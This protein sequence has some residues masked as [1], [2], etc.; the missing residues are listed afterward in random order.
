MT[1]VL[2]Q[3]ELS[4]MQ[5]GMLYHALGESHDGVDIEQVLLTLR[6]PVEEEPMRLAWQ[7]VAERHAILRSRFRW[8]GVAEPLQEV[9]ERVRIPLDRMDWRAVDAPERSERV[10]ALLAHDRARG[11]DLREAPLMRLTLVR[12]TGS[13]AL[14]LWSFHHALLDGRSYPLVL[15]EVF[16]EYEAECRGIAAEFPSPRPYR[17]YIEWLRT[18]DHNS[19]RDYWQSTLAGF[20]SPTPLGPAGARS[21][22]SE[23]GRAWGAHEIRLPAA[24]TLVLR[25]LARDGSVTLNTVL[26]GAWALLLHRYSGESDI[27]F[28]ATRAC[29]R[30]A[31]PGA[32]DMVGLFINT[33]PLRVRVD[34]ED[35]LIPWLQGLRT[36]QVTLRQFE[37]TPLA[38]IQGW[39]EVQRGTPIFESLLVFENQTFDTLLRASGGTWSE[40]RVGYIGQTNF[41]LTL[42][43][44][45]DQEMLLR[46]EYSRRRFGDRDIARM[47]GHLRT[48]LGA[49]AAQPHAR[50]A[51][52]PLLSEEERH[53][54]I[55]GWN[56][57][58]SYPQGACLHERFEQQA[59]RTPEA[60]A[61]VYEG[62]ALSYG[63]LNRRANRLAHRLRELGVQR[64]QLLGLRTERGPEMVVG[65]LGILKAGGAYLPL[66]PAYPRERVAFMLEDSGVSLVL[67]QGPLAADLEGL[68]V[69]CVLL[70]QAL[71]QPETNPAPVSRASDLAYVIYT[72]GST[73][74]PKGALITHYNVTRLFEA[75]QP[76]YGFGERDVWTLFHSYAFDFSVWELWGALLHGARVVIVP[77]WVSRSPEA[78]RE[79]LLRERVTVLNQTPS[80]FRQLLQAELAQPKADSLALRYVVFGGEALELQSLRPWFERYGDERPLLVNM[81][82]ITETTVHVTYRPIRLKD[83]EAGQGSVIGVPIPDLQL[84]ILEPGGEPAPIGVPGEMYVGGAGVARGYLKRAELSAQRFLPDR[85][86][87][88]PGARLYRTGDLARRLENGDIEYLGRID[89]QVKIRGFRIELGEIEAGIARHPAI[90]QV[91]VIAREDSPGDKRLVAYYVAEN[92]PAELLEQLRALIRAAMPEYMLPA[93]FVPLPAL[94][95]THNGK[96]DRKAL[97]APDTSS[98]DA[99]RPYTAPRTPMETAIARIWSSV[100]GVVRVGIHDHFF[101]LGGDSILSIQVIA[102]CR[103]EGLRLTPKDLFQRPTIAKLAEGFAQPRIETTGAL[104]PVAGEVPITPIQRW[105]LELDLV[106]PH[107][108]NQAF[109]FELPAETNVALLQH[110]LNHVVRQHDALRLRLRRNGTQ[111]HQ[112]YGPNQELQ[113]IEQIDLAACPKDRRAAAIAKRAG[114]AQASL[115]L[116]NGPLLRAVHFCL[117]PSEPA[118]LLLVIHHL[119]V[120]GVSWRLILEDLEAAYFS[121]QTDNPP[122]LPPRTTSF[123]SW[124]AHL[125]MFA[126]SPSASR[127]LAYWVAEAEKSVSTLPGGPNRSENLEGE[128]GVVSACLTVDATRALLQQ[129]PA[130]YRTRINDVLLTAL[131]RALQRW[132]GGEAFRIDLEG[133]GRE[134]LFDDVDISRTVGWFT[135]LFPVRLEMPQGLDD[136]AALKAIKEQ[137]HRIPDRGISYGL[138][139]YASDEVPTIAALSQAPRAEV[140]F[141]YLGQFDQVVAGSRLFGFASEPAGLWHSPRARRTHAL[142]VICQVRDGA[143][144]TQWIHHPASHS[145]ETIERV[146]RDFVAA[147]RGIIAHCLSAAAGGRTASDFP[148]AAIDQP[149]IDRFWA[150][151]PGFEDLYPLSPMQHLFYVM[152]G[153]RSDLGFEQWHLRAEGPLDSTLLR[154]AIERVVAR[155][156]ILRSVFVSE[157]GAAPVQLVLPQALLPW[158]EEDWRALAAGEQHTRLAQLLQSDRRAGFDLAQAPLMRVALRRTGNDVWHLVWSTHHLCIDGWSWP[159][160]LREVSAIYEGLLQGGEPTLQPAGTYRSYVSWLQEH[161]PH[162]EPFWR[163]ALAGLA[164]PT[165]LNL[166]A[167]PRAQGSSPVVLAEECTQLEQDTTA[168]LQALARAQ[169]LTLSTILQAAWSL[170]LSHYSGSPDVVFGAALSGRPAELSGIESLV[171]SCVNNLPVRVAVPPA[172]LLLPWLSGL[173]KQ[174]FELAQHQYAPLEQVQRWAKVPWRYRLFDSLIVFQNYQVDEAARRLG[175]DA[176]LVTMAAPEATNYPLTISATP[177]DQLRL[178]LIYQS[179]RLAQETVRSHAADLKTMLQSI[180]FSPQASLAQ[181]MAALPRATRGKA[182]A[183][184]V[185]PAAASSALRFSYAAPASETEQ[186]LAALWQDLFGVD[187]ISLDDN[188]YDLGGHS[189]LLLQAHSRLRASLQPDLPVV[190]LLQYPTI[191]SLARYLSGGAES[192]LVPAEARDRARKQR[193]AMLKQRTLKGHA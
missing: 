14:L 95:L 74:K 186:A 33:L 69:T 112:E 9:L 131:A 26:Q 90:R 149:Q 178:R 94:P 168:A 7:R 49:M 20:R 105:F 65:I 128:A 115:S 96:V 179:D 141:N 108:W 125:A 38:R 184:A 45:G 28:G 16:A 43:A 185:M 56:R 143:L 81:Y 127:S 176:R 187:R 182:A 191:R 135:S 99:A 24:T 192:A 180:A 79:L 30:S 40:R 46:L 53:Q 161:A 63:E 50:L 85:F 118:R 21:S 55:A 102:R 13:E 34:L 51:E 68:G 91:A 147:L 139:R 31:L 101:E 142:E 126:R 2:E 36:Q 193:E 150:R 25:N 172:Q 130:A 48:M 64:E 167:V 15:R 83:L 169:H 35:S 183:V 175:K 163:S 66:D 121:L 153:T 155:Q 73:G 88:A 87:T 160:V 109:L 17:D 120:D 159:I 170:L 19:A 62:E 32:L 133:H 107:H 61:L 144:E 132:T 171:G 57:S 76:W 5:A 1:R 59:Q 93:H 148:L 164:A 177:G 27:V 97:P 39:S 3:Y 189:L 123:Q 110:A 82:G 47:L 158:T 18:V 92:A 181:L 166:A 116:A 165:P 23:A 122:S 86:G 117:G 137:V 113:V 54:A 146:A 111:W 4:P 22:G 98:L 162:S 154:K 37:H 10:Q 152:E 129:V 140:L 114:E 80:A 190:A 174:Q 173:Q 78:F 119:A 124:A 41:P 70:E 52:L 156:T 145:R 42:V 77:Y 8:E 72:S 44:Y 58:V 188:F 104:A 134:D 151:Y 6:G 11:F 89:D 138:L 29:R 12:N 103:Q 100:L 136:A 84:Y 67:T 71:A 60:A 106:E 157:G 75:T